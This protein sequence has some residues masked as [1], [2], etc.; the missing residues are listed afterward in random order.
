MKIHIALA[1]DAPEELAGEVSER[2]ASL[3]TR[4]AMSL[5]PQNPGEVLIAG[6]F[7][8]SDA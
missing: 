1:I 3:I 7:P 4:L 8:G 2:V 6:P 5:E